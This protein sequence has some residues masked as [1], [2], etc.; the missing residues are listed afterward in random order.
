MAKEEPEA[1]HRAALLLD[2]V[3]CSAHYD[4]DMLDSLRRRAARSVEQ[5]QEWTSQDEALVES[6]LQGAAS[7]LSTRLTFAQAETAE[8]LR[9]YGERGFVLSDAVRELVSLARAGVRHVPMDRRAP[10]R[11]QVLEAPRELLPLAT[12]GHLVPGHGLEEAEAVVERA[13]EIAGEEAP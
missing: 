4:A 3:A 13:R 7:T 10:R 8:A 9:W 2:E 1:L 11:D 6:A 12:V 5:M